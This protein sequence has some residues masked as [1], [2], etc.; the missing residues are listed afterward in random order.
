MY[1]DTYT[2]YMPIYAH[3]YTVYIHKIHIRNIHVR[4]KVLLWS[5]SPPT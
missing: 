2:V 4:Q 3:P 5:I 1:H